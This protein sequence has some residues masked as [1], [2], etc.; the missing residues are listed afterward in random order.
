MCPLFCIATHNNSYGANQY[1]VWFECG[2][3][4]SIIP[5]IVRVH[6]IIETFGTVA[7]RPPPLTPLA[8]FKSFSGI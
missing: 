1:K 5:T 6:S 3:S 4:I 8:Y 7:A 2:Y